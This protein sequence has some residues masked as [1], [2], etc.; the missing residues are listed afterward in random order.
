MFVKAAEGFVIFPG[1]FGTLDELFEALTLI[2]TG[3]I[4]TSPSCSSTATIGPSCSTGSDGALL[5]DGTDLTRGRAAP[6]RNGR[7]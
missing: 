5:A 3:K 7:S 4:L 6:A 1:G 2:Q